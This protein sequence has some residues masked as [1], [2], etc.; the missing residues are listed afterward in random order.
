M[1]AH[2]D[3]KVELDERTFVVLPGREIGFANGAMVESSNISWSARG[4][5]LSV[6]VL[7]F[8]NG[9]TRIVA[10]SLALSVVEAENVG[11]SYSC[12]TARSSAEAGGNG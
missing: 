12:W 11:K 1:T 3:G 8:G 7:W 5:A 6:D 4:L 10:G 2:F 9:E